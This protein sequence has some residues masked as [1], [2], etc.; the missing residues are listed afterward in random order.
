MLTG[1]YRAEETHRRR[2]P[3]V[4]EARYVSS[5]VIRDPRAANAS[6]FAGT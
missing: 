6:G 3:R 4:A 2:K 1:L 5:A